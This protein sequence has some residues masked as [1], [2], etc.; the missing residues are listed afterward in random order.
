MKYIKV[1]NIDFAVD[2]LTGISLSEC[3]ALFS[4]VRKD[5][6]KIAWTKANPKAK[7]KPKASE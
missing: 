6:V 2:H 7:G 5:I 3:Q 4:H 1:G